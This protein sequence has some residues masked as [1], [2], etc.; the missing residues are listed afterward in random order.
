VPVGGGDNSAGGI[1]SA[2]EGGQRA[3]AARVTIENSSSA[4][5][6][7]TPQIAGTAHII[8]AVEDSGRPSLTAYRRIILN[9]RAAAPR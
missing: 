8:L 9:I 1:P 2:P 4:S 3:P 6:T 5:T 7:A